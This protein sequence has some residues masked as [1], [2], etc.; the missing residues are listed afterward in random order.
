MTDY[1]VAQEAINRLKNGRLFDAQSVGEAIEE[2]QRRK[3]D[4]FSPEDLW[5]EAKDNPSHPAYKHFDWDDTEA[6]NKW[7]THQAR[8]IIRLISVELP[9]IKRPVPAFMSVPVE[10]G[11][12]RYHPAQEV[13][14]SDY[15]VERAVEQA[16]GDLAAYADRLAMFQ[17][18]AALRESIRRT[19]EEARTVK[20]ALSRRRSRRTEPQPRV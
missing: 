12:R 2:L 3:G 10:T 4:D 6:A 18:L 13:L 17:E 16:A 9:N 5:Q 1:F 8:A 20:E 19:A 11:G 14:G 7:R 15:L